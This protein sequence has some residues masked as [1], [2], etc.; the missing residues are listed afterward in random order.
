MW[1]YGN[2]GKKYGMS[3]EGIRQILIKIAPVREVLL[4]PSRVNTITCKFCHLQ[5]TIYNRRQQ[6][7][8]RVCADKY[9]IEQT[10]KRK[11]KECSRCKETKPVNLFQWVNSKH[12]RIPGAYCRDC[13]NL[14]T[15]EWGMKNPEKKR[16]INKTASIKWQK[17]NREYINERARFRYHNDPVYRQKALDYHRLIRERAKLNKYG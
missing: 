17:N 2:L 3:H 8:S 14:V 10:D 9:S 13:S 4:A 6:F 15:K 16:E 12:R 11:E 7:C 5:K 1:S